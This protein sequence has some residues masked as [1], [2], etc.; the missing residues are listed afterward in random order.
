VLQRT[1]WLR[2]DALRDVVSL[3][4]GVGDESRVQ[5]HIVR[6]L[7]DLGAP[8]ADVVALGVVVVALLHDV[9]VAILSWIRAHARTIV[10]VAYA[11]TEQTNEKTEQLATSNDTLTVSRMQQEGAISTHSL[12][13]RVVVKGVQ[14]LKMPY[15]SC[16]IRHGRAVSSQ[17]APRRNASPD[18]DLSLG[19]TLHSDVRGWT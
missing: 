17:S 8:E 19:R 3:S 13:R 15:R 7:G 18:R 10:P 14:K 2:I 4:H 11:K 5:E 6:Q 16:C 1:D 12:N 9:E